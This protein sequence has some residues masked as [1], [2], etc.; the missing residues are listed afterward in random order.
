MFTKR[1]IKPHNPP[2]VLN[3][4]VMRLGRRYV[5]DVINMDAFEEIKAYDGRVLIVHG[6]KDNIV[7]LSYAERAIEAYRSKFQ[8]DSVD[9]QKVRLRIIEGG[10]HIFD[11]KRDKIAKKHLCDFIRE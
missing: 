3:C 4:G 6:T 1:T 7:N 10:T 11:K 8:P 2:E 5:A 9:N